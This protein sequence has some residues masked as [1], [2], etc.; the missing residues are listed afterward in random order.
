MEYCTEESKEK[1]RRMDIIFL[2]DYKIH[3]MSQYRDIFVIT[4]QQEPFLAINLEYF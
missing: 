2:F 4:V 3:S 1:E